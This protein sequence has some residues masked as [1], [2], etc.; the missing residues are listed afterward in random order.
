MARPAGNT[1]PLVEPLVQ[2]DPM[3]RTATAELIA[4]LEP[5]PHRDRLRL[6]ATTAREL[7]AAGELEPVLAELEDA[8][9]YGRRLAALAAFATRRTGYLAARLTDPDPV[10]RGYALR[11]VRSLPVPDAAI[12]A[13]CADASAVVRR[14]LTRAV[15]RSG[16]PELAEALVGPLRE[17]W[18]DYEA[19]A[20]L[21]VCGPAAVARLLPELADSVTRWPGLAARHPGPV[22]D[23]AEAELAVLPTGLR[24]HWWSRRAPGLTAA[25]HAQPLRVLELLER[26]GADAPRHL[27]RRHYGL[28]AEA[29]A[30]RFVRWL[31]GPAGAQRRYEP[32]PGPSV[33]R[34]IVRADP[35][36]LTRLGRL[37][38]QR[39]DELADL[40]KAFPPARREGF[41]DALLRDFASPAWTMPVLLYPLLP[42]ERRY[43]EARLAVARERAAG[44]RARTLPDSLVH[45]P[46]AEARAE[47]LAACGSSDAGLRA[48][49]WAK[50]IANAAPSGDPGTVAEVL[51]LVAGRLRNEREPVR[52]AALA[53]LAKLPVALLEAPGTPG[54]LGTITL[55]ALRARDCSPTS[56]AALQSLVRGVFNAPAPSGALLD[57]AR[58]TIGLFGTHIGTRPLDLLRPAPGRSL[59]A[60]ALE[61][62]RPGVEEASRKGDFGPLLQLAAFPDHHYGY[63]YGP[64]RLP[65]LQPMLA[66]ALARCEDKDAP[67]LAAVW[68]ADPATREERAVELLT[69]DPSAAA[70]APVGEIL[71]AHRTDLLD[72]L[73][74]AEPP[75]GR[76]LGEDSARPLP[77]FARAT[78]WLPRQQEAAARLAATAVRDESRALHER[79]AVL[80]EAVRIPEHGLELVREFADSTQTVLAEAALTAAPR[81]VEPAATLDDLFAHAGDDLARV[82]LYAAARAAAAT[83][84][85]VL[86]PRLAELLDPARR[87]KVTSRKEA[88]RLA[89]RLLPPP[90]AAALLS[91][92][93]DHPDSHRDL[94]ATAMRLASRLLAAESAWELLEAAASMTEDSRLPILHTDPLSVPRAHRRRYAGLVAVA[95][96]PRTG[97]DALPP[98]YPSLPKWAAYAPEVADILRLAVCD[99]SL[100]EGGQSAAEA[101]A[102]IAASGLPHPLGGAEPGS[103]FHGAVEELLRLV[104]GGADPDAEPEGDLPALRRLRHLATQPLGK[105]PA[106]REAVLRQLAD[107]PLLAEARVTL[108]LRAVDLRADPAGMPAALRELVAAL[109]GRPGLA[110][111]TASGLAGRYL[112][113]DPLPDLPAALETVR[114]LARD[115]GAEAGLFAAA[116]TA[117]VGARHAWPERWRELLRELRRH[118]EV[119]VR[120][121]AFAAATQRG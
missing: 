121:A 75:Y 110:R 30:E 114:E 103:P 65:E 116:L 50:L 74:G 85:S 77:V 51:G 111:A 58:H 92:I 29:D 78:R 46:V 26:Y 27:L 21:S 96:R 95:A 90:L 108:L 88:A 100:R 13:A 55:D 25:A 19:A 9:R 33:L 52:S 39:P 18:G 63:G 79:A 97:P 53:E 67:A 44:L 93:L 118:P 40:L 54:H 105:D 34:R 45:L 36:S 10:V 106:V 112:H 68:L 5:L 17:K 84:P 59:G 31:A 94:V 64:A 14:Q 6:A 8:G 20:L 99:L 117:S 47:I 109:R 113:G 42:P 49:G 35:P 102:Q 87:V 16:R 104:R 72:V 80:R 115:G 7:A 86:A 2:T 1:F 66:D 91:R 73:L 62:L 107:E 56:R 60:R 70:L 120:D 32:A 37:W 12:V 71:S 82:A 4:A 89:V 48:D 28:L 15:R 76:F 41:L 98:S 61:A 83:A 119:E 101:L 3:S 69:R 22:L 43:A 24:S 23:Q 38:L 81:T 11:A 57:W